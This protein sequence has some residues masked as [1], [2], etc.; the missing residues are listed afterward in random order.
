MFG[1]EEIRGAVAKACS[2]VDCVY[3][4]LFGSRATGE[5]RD[6]SDVD[7]AIKFRSSAGYVDKVLKMT[8]SIEEDLGVRV[9]VVPLN[10]ADTVVKYEAFSRGVLL[11]CAD[12]DAYIDDFVNA[13]DE[14]LD[15]EH[16]FNKFYDLVVKEIRDACSRSQG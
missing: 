12:S 7:V 2:G 16:T 6:Y 9:D 11:F 13:V 15:F 3:A 10:A 1:L 4:L 5:A 14:Y 8:S